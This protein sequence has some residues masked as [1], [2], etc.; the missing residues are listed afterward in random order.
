MSK[1][2]SSIGS[3]SANNKIKN[4]DVPDESESLEEVEETDYNPFAA[5][6]GHYMKY[7][8]GEK[9]NTFDPHKPYVETPQNSRVVPPVRNHFVANDPE[10]E[11]INAEINRI[12]QQKNVPE[13]L[14]NFSRKRLDILI[15]MSK[16]NREVIIDDVAIE[17][18]SLS[19]KDLREAYV[20]TSKFNETVE[21]SYELRR[22]ILSRSIIKIAGID[23][24]DFI[25]DYNYDT[26]LELVDNLGDSFLNRLF[27]EY[28]IL[29]KEVN[30][31]YTIKNEKEMKEVV[32]D[33][34]K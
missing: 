16:L 1:I 12:K 11:S 6:E 10:P 9:K 32:E 34:K 18:Q 7:R 21:F 31:K 20:I 30:S 19:S 4:Y 26:V 14:S 17:L 33:L 8:E 28:Q 5:Y 15:G 27:E 23:I 2:E 29:N 24:Y 22:Q 3:I 13:K 25:G